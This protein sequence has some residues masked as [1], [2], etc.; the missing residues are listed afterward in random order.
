MPTLT[1]QGHCGAPRHYYFV[2]GRVLALRL[3]VEN[4][5]PL[6]APLSP[7]PSPSTQHKWSPWAPFALSPTLS[8][9]SPYAAACLYAAWCLRLH[10]LLPG[11]LHTA[12][13]LCCLGCCALWGGLGFPCFCQPI[14]T[15]CGR[16]MA[17][18]HSLTV[19]KRSPAWFRNSSASMRH[20]DLTAASSTSS[21][22]RHT[23]SS[24]AI[25]SRSS[26]PSTT[27]ASI[28]R[29]TPRRCRWRRSR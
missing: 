7:S 12:S 1:T 25:R 6:H 26:G 22:W 4:R 21:L 20:A 8:P 15:C 23:R 5:T 29:T 13:Y 18:Y 28:P 24:S 19:S 2:E 3:D 16:T 10:A 17:K 27:A 11:A 9:Q 14:G